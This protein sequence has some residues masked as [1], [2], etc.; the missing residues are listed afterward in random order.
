MDSAID[1]INEQICNL[2]DNPPST[3]PGVTPAPS[4]AP[5]N[6]LP[7]TDASMTISVTYDDFPEETG[8]SLESG[9]LGAFLFIKPRGS[10]TVEGAVITESFPNLPAGDYTFSITDV[11]GDGICC[12]YGTGSFTISNTA[13]GETLLSGGED[14]LFARGMNV[15]LRVSSTGA[16]SL[17]SFSTDLEA[18]SATPSAVPSAVPSAMPSMPPSTEF[19]EYKYLTAI[20]YGFPGAIGRLPTAAELSGVTRLTE[21]YFR[22]AIASMHALSYADVHVELKLALVNL[23][24]LNQVVVDFETTV[25]FE[26][27]SKVPTKDVVEADLENTDTLDIY[28]TNYVDVAEPGDSLFKE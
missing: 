21:I 4:P 14:I 12:E 23:G 16:L 28:V 10:V 7:T 8:W 17:V 26:R 27:L 2:S 22:R 24:A 25:F 5:T 20:T 11:F 13:T 9:P 18:P 1:W 15:I 6:P 19:T 3:C